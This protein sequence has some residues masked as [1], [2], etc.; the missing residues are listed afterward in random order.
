MAEGCDEGVPC[1]TV[2]GGMVCLGW[3]ADEEMEGLQA[4]ASQQLSDAA[5]S[6]FSNPNFI[7]FNAGDEGKKQ[8]PSSKKGGDSAEDHDPGPSK[9]KKR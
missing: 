4:S 7:S 9:K 5:A 6:L 2:G 3:D 8:K 1:G